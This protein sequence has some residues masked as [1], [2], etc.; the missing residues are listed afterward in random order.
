M[1]GTRY[2]S[3]LCTLVAAAVLA[4]CAAT[5]PRYPT[6]Y[7][8]VTELRAAGL[9]PVRVN[10]FTAAP[11]ADRRIES[12]T[13]RGGKLSSP[14]GTYV[15]YLSE[16][17]K[18]DLDHA[19]LLDEQSGVALDGVLIRNSIDGSGFTTGF[20]EIEARLTVSRAGA[21]VYEATKAV[22]HEWPSNMV[23]AVAIPRAISNYGAA[24]R[25]L[26]ADFYADPGFT[27]ALRKPD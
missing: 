1:P 6:N 8:A 5:A 7:P 25:K 21:P 14:Y 17:L 22:R 20:A 16:A 13:I 3:A 26:L 4:G 19:G 9:A 2:R 11:G 24:V 27:A 15:A 18:D 23:G 10:A 12:L